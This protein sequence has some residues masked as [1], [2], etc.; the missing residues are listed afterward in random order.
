MSE[1]RT[2]G[3]LAIIAALAVIGFVLVMASSG[4]S[5]VG[6]LWVEV[7]KAA[8]QVVVI[9][10]LGTALKLLADEYQVRRQHADTREEFRRD[11]YRRLVAVTGQLRAVPIFIL[12]NRSVQTWTKQMQTVVQADAELRQLEHEI[13]ASATV[14]SPPFRDSALIVQH[15]ET[16]VGYT[17][18]V[19]H[20]F[21]EH[22]KPLGEQQRVAEEA[23]L[24]QDERDKRQQGLWATLSAL[25]SVKDMV[26]NL[27]G[28]AT[29]PA[30]SWG[31]Y[32]AEET[33]ALQ[34]ML[35]TSLAQAGA[36]ST[37]PLRADARA[38]RDVSA[39]TPSPSMRPG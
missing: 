32:V 11:K 26:S 34:L 22:K 25:P 12:A 2:I 28:S 24:S 19:A 1:K 16:M 8:L 6:Q 15:L 10:V 5:Q 30:P 36:H 39:P 3:W 29:T 14:P 31:A 38:T 7:G 27:D 35:Q 13:L 9:G 18:W 17:T 37:P 4:A 21:A 23:D 33:A 20:D